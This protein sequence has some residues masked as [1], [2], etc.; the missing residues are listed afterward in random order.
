MCD[1]SQYFYERMAKER[2]DR[3]QAAAEHA[4]LVR[5]LRE[6]RRPLRVAVGTMLVALGRVIL[7]GDRAVEPPRPGRPPMGALGASSRSR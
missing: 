4:A 7:G 3:L 5:T 6:P 2:A 1:M